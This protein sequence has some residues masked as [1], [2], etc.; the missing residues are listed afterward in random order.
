MEQEMTDMDNISRALVIVI[1]YLGSK[2]N[3]E[4]YTEDDDLKIVEE[5][6]SILVNATS[7]E[8]AALIRA[9]KELGLNEWAAQ[10][11]ID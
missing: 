4:E 8:R 2:R 5:A 7:E 6:A 10:I 3:D 1:Q 11:G 9:A